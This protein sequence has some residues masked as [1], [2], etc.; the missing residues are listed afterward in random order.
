MTYNSFTK[1]LILSKVKEIATW[2]VEKYNL[3]NNK[4]KYILDVWDDLPNTNTYVNLE[5]ESFKINQLIPYSSVKINEL[6]VTNININTPNY[7]YDNKVDF[8]D[9]YEG[10]SKIEYG[11][12]STK[13]IRHSCKIYDLDIQHVL[14]SK[15][16][17][18]KIKTYLQS[19]YKKRTNFIVKNFNRRLNNGTYS[20]KNTLHLENYPKSEWRKRILEYQYVENQ[21]KNKIID[22]TNIES[23]LEFLEW[24]TKKKQEQK[25]NRKYNTYSGNY[26]VLSKQK[27]EV[28]LGIIS[29]KSIGKGY[30]VDKKTFN[31]ESFH[32]IPKLT[33]CFTEENKERAKEF[34]HIFKKKITIAVVGKNEFNKIKTIHNVMTEEEFLKSKSFKRTI[35]SIVYDD[36]VSKYENLYSREGQ[37]VVKNHLDSFSSDIQVLKNYSNTNG[38]R[39]NSNL[40][41]ELLAYAKE[42]NVY[43]FEYQDV[44]NRVKN[45]IEK[46]DFINLLQE[47]SRYDE[48]GKANVNKLI[49]Q[50]LL[51]RKKY[52]NQYEDLEIEVKPKVLVPVEEVLQD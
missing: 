41:E 6:K 9:E 3:D 21:F 5:E 13:H 24:D 33:I 8:N 49:A 16:P 26:K 39:I 4:E 27:G 30:K 25:E 23:S 14:V 32:K 43:D 29:V 36:L 22:E 17:T 7:Y 11:K 1:E 45:N 44:Y 31:I 48:K 51:F 47:P 10:V 20:Y 46:Y 12:Y 38:K 28:T 35:T 2:F 19:K 50:I 52:H 34:Y 37:E 18:G 40:E 42:H 15:T